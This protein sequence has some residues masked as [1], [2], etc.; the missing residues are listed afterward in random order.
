MD[1]RKSVKD[2]IEEM[3][4]ELREE[5]STDL[6]LFLPATMREQRKRALKHKKASKPKKHKPAKKKAHHKAKPKKANKKPKK[7]K[8]R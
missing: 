2:I 1:E 3:R 5:K 6:D 7:K 8:K 4:K